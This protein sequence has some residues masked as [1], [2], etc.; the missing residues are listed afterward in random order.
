MNRIFSLFV[1]LVVLFSATSCFGSYLTGSQAKAAGY[2]PSS[3]AYFG[4]SR[5]Y[6]SGHVFQTLSRNECLVS[7]NNYNV[8][9]IESY[10]DVFFDEKPI[11]GVY[12]FVGTYSYVTKDDRNKVVPIYVLEKEF[13]NSPNSFPI[14]GEKRLMK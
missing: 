3:S 7:T 4:N 13:K 2:S 6:I 9:K 8:L 12:I 5:A 1:F 11:N 10:S 14:R